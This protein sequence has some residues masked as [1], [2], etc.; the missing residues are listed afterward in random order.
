MGIKDLIRLSEGT[1]IYIEGAIEIEIM[2][3]L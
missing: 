1:S 3:H 2:T